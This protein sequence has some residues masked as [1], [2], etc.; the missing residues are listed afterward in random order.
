MPEGG[1]A[2]GTPAPGGSKEEAKPA[3]HKEEGKPKEGGKRNIFFLG[4]KESFTYSSQLDDRC[5][6]WNPKK[7]DKGP[8]IK[9]VRKNLPFSDPPP[10]SSGGVRNH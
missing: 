3:D 6:I 5:V 2:G 9:D 7:V 10:P 8:S 1:K 4:G